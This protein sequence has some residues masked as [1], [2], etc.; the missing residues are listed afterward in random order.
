MSTA[1]AF[2][3][4]GLTAGERVFHRQDNTT[5]VKT[6]YITYRTSIS[7][8]NDSQ[9]IDA[10]LR[11]YS[12]PSAVPMED[13]TIVRMRGRLY[14]PTADLLLLEGVRMVPFPGDPS[15][16]A[17]EAFFP[18][19][20][21][22]D[23]ILHGVV[24]SSTTEQTDGSKT[25]SL[26]VSDYVRD[27]TRTS[28]ISCVF[29]S[30]HNTFP[31]LLTCYS[32]TSCVIPNT[33]RWTRAP[34]PSLASSIQ[35]QGICSKLTSNNNLE[36]IVDNIMYST[37]APS[38]TSLPTDSLTGKGKRRKFAPYSSAKPYKRKD[39]PSSATA[40]DYPSSSSTQLS[41]PAMPIEIPGFTTQITRLA[42]N[43][44]VTDHEKPAA[45]SA[46]NSDNEGRKKKG[47]K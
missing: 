9:G 23:V 45:Q 21:P 47:R 20:D 27:N 16:E 42:C 18:E 17:Y 36:V 31:P 43:D 8:A 46:K 12:P 10:E 24:A 5:P 30:S 39:Q 22:T 38:T 19:N 37:T 33:P 14:A 34:L 44:D 28:T 41:Q 7:C 15:S 13:F 26:T 32:F 25:F 11:V 35:I 40:I 6:Y 29:K 3:L 2:G 1:T 4:F